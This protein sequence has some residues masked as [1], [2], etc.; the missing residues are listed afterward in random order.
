VPD[1]TAE[2]QAGSAAGSPSAEDSADA[3]DASATPADAAPPVSGEPAAKPASA[4]GGSGAAEAGAGKGPARSA[5]WFKQEM[6]RA[7]YAGEHSKV[8]LLFEDMVSAGIPPGLQPFNQFVEAVATSRSVA[9]ARL[10]V[11]ALTAKHPALK[12]DAST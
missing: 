2:A 12:P 9:D 7:L 11:S 5:Q 3:A 8:V 1:A 10:A 6:E 4:V